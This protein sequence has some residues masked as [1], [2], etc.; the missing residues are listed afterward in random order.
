MEPRTA[1]QRHAFGALSEGSDRIRPASEGQNS[2]GGACSARGVPELL[3]S[4]GLVSHARELERFR[5]FSCDLDH[6]QKKFLQKKFSG[7]D[8][9]VM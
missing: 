6:V 5:S 3:R 8:E 1:E 7:L 9:Q 4:P 2:A